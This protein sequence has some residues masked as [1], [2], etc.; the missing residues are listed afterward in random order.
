MR[1]T[2]HSNDIPE[3]GETVTVLEDDTGF[4]VRTARIEARTEDGLILWLEHQGTHPR[5][6]FEKDG[7]S[8]LW[9]RDLP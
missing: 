8:P 5:M 2:I 9:I 6:I 3:V 7:T 1:Y 4:A